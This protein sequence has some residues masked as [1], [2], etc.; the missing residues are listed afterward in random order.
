MSRSYKKTAYCGDRKTKSNKRLANRAVRNY[1]KRNPEIV[2][3]YREF[4]KIFDSYDICDYYWLAPDFEVWAQAQ[5]DRWYF[6]YENGLT[7]KPCP[8]KKELYNRYMKYYK[9]K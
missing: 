2:M 9:R 5:L 3:N 8:T 6:W 1:F 4:K 7:K